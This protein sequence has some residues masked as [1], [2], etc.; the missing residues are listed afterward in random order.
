MRIERERKQLVL[1]HQDLTLVVY[2]ERGEDEAE[3]EFPDSRF[4]GKEEKFFSCE[5][6][7]QRRV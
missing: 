7:W 2:A 3:I 5:G 1:A 6:H 4:D